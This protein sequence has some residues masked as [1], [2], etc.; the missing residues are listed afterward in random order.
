MDL[1]SP[2]TVILGLEPRIHIRSVP[3]M[4]ARVKPEH[5]EGE[6]A[7]LFS[8]QASADQWFIAL[9]MSSVIFLASPSSIIVPSL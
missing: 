5:D 9:T 4:D 8:L 3:V 1:A 6:V 2:S 7:G